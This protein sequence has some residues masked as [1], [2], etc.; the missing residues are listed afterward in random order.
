[1]QKKRP[2]WPEL[3]RSMPKYMHMNNA[4]TDRSI[5]TI[6]CLCAF[7]SFFVMLVGIIQLVGFVR[8]AGIF[9]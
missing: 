5:V 8:L 3:S 6:T 2:Y 4:Y 1:M 9:G 7:I